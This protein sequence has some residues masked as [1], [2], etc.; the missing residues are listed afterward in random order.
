MM[1]YY[2]VDDVEQMLLEESAS[3]VEQQPLFSSRVN[4]Q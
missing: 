3:A 4:K 1:H 2:L